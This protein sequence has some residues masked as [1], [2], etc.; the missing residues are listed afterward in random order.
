MKTPEEDNLDALLHRAARDDRPAEWASDV[1]RGMEARVL[2]RIARPE[3]WGEAVFSLS[4]WRPL[5]AAAAAVLAIAAWSGRNTADVF[6][7]DWLMSQTTD[8]QDSG[9]TASSL[10][11]LEF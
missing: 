5:A 8:E 10:E 7:E 4:S 1:S 6:N 2:K 3:S 11:D 9:L